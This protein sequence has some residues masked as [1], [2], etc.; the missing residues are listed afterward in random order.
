MKSVEK[1]KVE[2]MT[3]AEQIKD[4][5]MDLSFLSMLGKALGEDLVGEI[6]NK[7]GYHAPERFSDTVKR[8]NGTY[9][10]IDSNCTPDHGYETM[11]F[12]CDSDGNVTD[13]GE[14][15]AEWY[16]TADEMRIGH[17]RIV[18]KWKAS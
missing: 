18:S 16:D 3:L 13:W 8:P 14:L 12:S 17:A 6:E 4:L 1:G 15:D 5:D 2:I 10:W 11:V 7:T 9:V